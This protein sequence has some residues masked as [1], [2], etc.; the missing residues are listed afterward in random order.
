MLSLRPLER[1]FEVLQNNQRFDDHY[2]EIHG[3]RWPELAEALKRAGQK[4]NKVAVSLKSST[5]NGS[6][7][8][9]SK[10]GLVCHQ[11]ALD[12]HYQ[13]DLASVLSVS[14]LDLKPGSRVLD[15]CAAPGGKSLVSQ[16]ILNG[17]GEWHMN[18]LSQGRLSRMKS[19]MREFSPVPEEQLHFYKRD[20]SKWGLAEQNSYEIVIC[21][22]PCSGEAHLL[23]SPSHLSKW[24]PKSSKNLSVRQHAILC[25]ALEAVKPGGQI[26]YST[27]SV[28]PQENDGVIAK[29]LKKRSD[30]ARVLQPEAFGSEPTEFGFQFFPDTSDMGPIY[31][32]VL[33]KLA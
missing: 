12:S 17:E 26:L 16:L 14:A 13:M 33:E 10:G 28:N 3:E 15:L 7:V 20:A 6:S 18:E 8:M 23:N 2:S 1:C 29:F 27:C 32:C 9:F 21:D 22:V 5:P 30:R 11:E 25:A 19:V 31:F 24:T 4:D